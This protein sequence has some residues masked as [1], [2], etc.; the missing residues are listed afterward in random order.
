MILFGDNLYT[1]LYESDYCLELDIRLESSNKVEGFYFQ[2]FSL[3]Q[4][5][6]FTYPNIVIHLSNQSKVFDSET[7]DDFGIFYFYYY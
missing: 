2:L 1:S 6:I 3:L 4:M 7:L 5:V